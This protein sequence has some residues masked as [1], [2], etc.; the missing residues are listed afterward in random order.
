MRPNPENDIFFLDLVI[1]GILQVTE[2]GDVFVIKSNKKLKFDTSSN[3]NRITYSKT[4]I[5][6]H[7]LVYQV[8]H[9][10]IPKNFT[11]NHIDGDKLNNYYKNLE[12]VTYQG[13]SI[14]ARDTGLMKPC[15]GE[16]NGN[17]IFS[18][19]EVIQIRNLH[20]E[21]KFNFDQLSEKFNTTWDNIYQIV[22][23][24]SYKHLPIQYDV[25]LSKLNRTKVYSKKYKE[26]N[27]IISLYLKG[28]S[29]YDI[30]KV[31]TTLSRATI[32]RIVR[33]HKKENSLPVIKS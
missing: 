5:Q 8:Y 23:G 10:P 20:F 17:A 25:H 21:G 3:Y 2:Y 19:Q 18:D 11:I 16:T 29:C 30:S 9:G 28:H 15:K 26:F 33:W 1:R 12:A 13:N 32:D 14:H 6:V 7:R 24:Y 31:I 27:Q 4:Q 22:T